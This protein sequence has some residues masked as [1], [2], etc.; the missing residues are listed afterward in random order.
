MND[1]ILLD[2]LR[3]K[4]R[5]QIERWEFVCFHWHQL[6]SSNTA[7]SRRLPLRPIIYLKIVCNKFL[8]Q[9]SAISVHGTNWDSIINTGMLLVPNQQAPELVLLNPPVN[10][11]NKNIFLTK[12]IF[13]LIFFYLKNYFLSCVFLRPYNLAKTTSLNLKFCKGLFKTRLRF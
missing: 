7:W 2:V 5:D 3:F 8:N 11:T 12:N 1:D 4:M 13:S 9:F 10:N 6:I